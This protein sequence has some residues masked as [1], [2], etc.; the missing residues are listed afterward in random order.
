M[1]TLKFERLNLDL[2]DNIRKDIN[3][4]RRLAQHCIVQPAA[5]MSRTACVNF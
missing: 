1:E 5:N 3:Q 4:K 2:N